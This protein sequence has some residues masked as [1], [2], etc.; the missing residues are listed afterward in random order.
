MNTQSDNHSQ[1]H[2]GRCGLRRG[3]RLGVMVALLLGLGAVL[4]ALASIT[5]NVAAHGHFGGWRH[6]GGVHSI[7]QAHD[8]ARDV[9]AWVLGSVDATS[10]QEEQVQTVMSGLVDKIYP[11]AEQHRENRRTLIAELARTTVD[12]QVLQ[13]IRSAE[14]ALADTASA[15]LVD[16]LADIATAL[17]PE[18]RQKLTSLAARFGH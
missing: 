8:R 17:T 1:E 14:L 12:R 3:V 6:H 5:F 4:G 10:T 16:A 13:E 11:L 7:E 18:Q 15:E 2:Q 9:T